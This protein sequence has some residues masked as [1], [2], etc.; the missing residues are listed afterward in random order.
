MF[1]VTLSWANRSPC[2]SI[3]AAVDNFSSD[4]HVQ[5]VPKVVSRRELTAAQVPTANDR[6]LE[7]SQVEDPS[8]IWN[9]FISEEG[10]SG[11][12]QSTVLYLC[13]N[14]EHWGRVSKK[15]DFVLFSNA[16]TGWG[17]RNIFWILEGLHTKY[18]GHSFLFSQKGIII[19]R[20]SWN[21][22][23]FLPIPLHASDERS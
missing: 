8:G 19:I 9:S 21:C 6:Q 13:R 16:G 11:R 7:I 18:A 12:G 4:N 20:F 23:R 3:A 22:L 15:R 2:A 5:T 10:S 14:S 1:R 17:S